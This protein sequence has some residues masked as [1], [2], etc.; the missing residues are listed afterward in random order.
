LDD[1]VIPLAEDFPPVGEQAWMDLV[2]KTLKGQPFEKRLVVRTGDG[3]RIEPLYTAANGELPLG[4]AAAGPHAQGRWDIRARVQHPDPVAANIAALQELEGGADSL[5]IAVDPSGETGVA[6]G[7]AADLGQVLEGVFIDLATVALDAGPHAL[8][9]AEWLLD[10]GEA[11]TLKPRLVLHLDPLSTFAETGAAVGGIEAQIAAAAKLAGRDLALSVFL[12]SGRAAHEAGGGEAA[13]LGFA[14]ASA[15]AY[16]RAGIAAG[17]AP[18]RAFA[19]ITLGLSADGDYFLTLAKHRAARSLWARVT[20]AALGSPLPARI[21][22]RS[23]RRMLAALDPWVNLLR[24][25]AAGFGAATGGADAIVLDAFSQPLCGSGGQ[26]TAFA[27]RQARNTQ[28]VLM[29]ESHLGRVADPAA[30]SWYLESVSRKLAEAGWAF[31]QKIEAAGGVA[32]ALESGLIADAIQ[33]VQAARTADIAKRRTG[34]IGVS[35]FPDLAEAG[36]DLDLV[37]PRP[38]AR[39]APPRP[40]DLAGADSRCTPLRPWRAAAPFEALRARAAVLA[41]RPKVFLATLGAPADYTAR[42]GFARNLFA[43]GGI[44]ADTGEATD[45]RHED[46]PLAAICSSD[47]LYAEGAEEAARTLKARG[48][49]HVYLAGRPGELEA[50]LQAAGVDS[51]LYAGMDAPAVLSRALDI[52]ERH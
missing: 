7:S 22:T 43:A 40:L 17:R 37:D 9:A 50:K 33:P 20:G 10:L 26:P 21:E 2:E 46:A 36:V 34:L 48:A 31:M 16:A 52:V 19:D 29:E 14:L 45:Y 15:L 18:A 27:R 44:A 41:P 28:L 25:T 4:G 13:E 38:F 6:I 42:L 3:V 1:G 11:R 32:A 47:A 5:L 30:G 12:A 24:L 49:R 51:F 35:E 39:P 23:S 8:A